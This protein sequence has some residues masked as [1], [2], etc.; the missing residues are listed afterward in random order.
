VT[1]NIPTSGQTFVAGDNITLAAAA[2]DLGGS[3]SKVDF[4]QGSGLGAT[5]V[6]SAYSVVWN[7]V[8]KGV[9]DLTAK[10]TDNSGLSTTSAVVS[11]SVANSPNSVNKAKGHAGSLAQVAQQALYTGA[12]DGGD[13]A[14]NTTLASDI[15][16]LT[17]D[18]QQ[19]YT[20]FEA[21]A[22]VFGVSTPAID[23]QL[24]AAILFSKASTGLAMKV[25][26]SQN[27]KNNLLR[28]GAHLAIAEDLMRYGIITKATADQAVATGARTNIVI[29]QANMGYNLAAV[30]SVAPASL[31]SISG[32][33][34]VQPMVSQTSFASLLANGS[35]PYEVGGLSVTVNGVAVPVLYASPWG[36]RFFMPGDVPEGTAE[37][38]VSSQDG[39]VCQGLISVERNASRI[40]TD[41]EDEN[42]IAVAT[43]G[44]KGTA[45]SFDVTTA[46][47]FGADKRTRVN[48]FATGIS[49]SVYNTDS[50]ND[51]QL[52]GQTRVNLAEGITIEARLGNGQ[53][54]NLP[55]EFA[56]A[57]GIVPGLDQ[58]TVILIPQ[59]KGAGTVQL[60]LIIGGRRSNA[61]TIS[62][63]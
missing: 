22:G 28:I 33:G 60:T 6:T 1:L 4:Y 26:L 56:G 17:A 25:P 12:A 7:N 45:P 8:P 50:S 48:F 44:Q 47:N 38:I 3:I 16:A 10:A 19:A 51:V 13:G 55:V 5:D 37:V 32:A 43:N 54:L 41:S 20:E 11:I 59:L 27:I 46:E 52:N 61:P 40:L 18:I 15:T 24:R 21:E 49:G 14:T 58:I 62:I 42:S 35:A 9:Y 57:Q 30:S 53:V 63:K 36:I 31:A 34:N 39:Y 23:V 2:T 29:G